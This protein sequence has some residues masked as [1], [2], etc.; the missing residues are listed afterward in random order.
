MRHMIIR[1]IMGLIWAAAG[2]FMLATGK[3]E[4][5]FSILMGAVFGYSAYTMWKKNKGA[6]N[7]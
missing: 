4:G 7:K 6:E 3:S 2:V 1:G 5:A